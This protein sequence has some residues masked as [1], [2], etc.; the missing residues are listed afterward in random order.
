MVKIVTAQGATCHDPRSPVCPDAESQDETG[1]LRTRTPPGGSRGNTWTFYPQSL[2]RRTTPLTSG[3]PDF[4][5][6]G[7]KWDPRSE[8][9]ETVF[10]VCE[11]RLSRGV[12][13]YEGRLSRGVSRPPSAPRSVLGTLVKGVSRREGPTGEVGAPRDL[14]PG[15]IP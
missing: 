4:R 2:T 13:P 5:P 1:Y 15:G 9:S 3:V 7:E 6:V 14:C 8:T 11:G 10:R 12:R